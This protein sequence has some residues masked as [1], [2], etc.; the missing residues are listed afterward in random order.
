MFVSA[1]EQVFNP[2]VWR[3]INALLYIF[4]YSATV[5]S[6]P[7]EWKAIGEEDVDIIVENMQANM[8]KRGMAQI[9]VQGGFQSTPEER[10]HKGVL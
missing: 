3:V 1:S 7:I 6:L 5:I 4:I 9:L 2:D 8:D 10:K